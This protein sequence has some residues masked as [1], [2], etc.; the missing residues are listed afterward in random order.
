MV[1]RK[2]KLGSLVYVLW[3]DAS[4]DDTWE[5]ASLEECST[6]VVEIETIGWVIFQDD[7]G[8]TIASTQTTENKTHCN[9]IAIPLTCISEVE[10]L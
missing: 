1:K 8:V 5:S 2:L 7:V 9:R 6:K 4:S 3:I 10:Y